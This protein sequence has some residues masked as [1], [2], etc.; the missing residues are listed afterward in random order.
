MSWWVI[1][2]AALMSM[3]RAVQQGDDPDIVFAEHY[4][5]SE[6]QKVDPHDD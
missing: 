4:A 2:D 1:E 5:N 6:H 3:L